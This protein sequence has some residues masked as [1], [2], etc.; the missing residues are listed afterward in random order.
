[1]ANEKQK[2]NL[3]PFNQMSPE[4]HRELSSRGG[5][6]C[7]SKKKRKKEMSKALSLLLALPVNEQ[8][9][10]MME[11]FGIDPEDADN[12]MAVLMA[13]LKEAVNGDV[14]AMQF[15]RD[16]ENDIENKRLKADMKRF[17]AEQEMNQKRIELLQAQIEELK[18]SA[19]AVD[20]D[21][22]VVIV[23]NLDQLADQIEEV[24]H[25]EDD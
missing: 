12:Q 22:R 17:K 6:A 1:M 7:Q 4:R 11:A 10:A 20:D 16:T 8:N 13:A 2:K 3:I 14:R 9:R 21:S 18:R 19:Q 5:I 25:G 24:D 15:I 23:N